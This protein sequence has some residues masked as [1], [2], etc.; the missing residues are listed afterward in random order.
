MYPRGHATVFFLAMIVLIAGLLAG[1]GG[2]DQSGSGSQQGGEAESQQGDE[3]KGKRNA[4]EKKIALGTIGFVNP[5]TETFT[6]HLS[7]D[8]K[9]EKPVAFRLKPKGK[10]TL[11]DKEAKLDDIKK[12]QQARVE[13]VVRKDRN[14]V[15]DVQL[16]EGGGDSGTNEDGGQPDGGGEKTG[17]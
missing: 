3:A 9:G 14:L 8:K 17:G 4:P 15:R 16:F 11:G 7:I 12:G 5:K 6:M 13:Y 1:C 10:I 2:S